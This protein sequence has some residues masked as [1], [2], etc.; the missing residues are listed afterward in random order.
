MTHKERIQRQLAGEPVDRIPMIGGWNMGVRNLAQI[1]G[2]SVE[3]YLADPV[4]GVLQANRRLRVDG[5]VPYIIPREVS[6]IRTGSLQEANFA[7]AEP[8]ALL[9][10]AEQIPATAEGVRAKHI[11]DITA[12]EDNYRQQFA[13]MQAALGDLELIPNFWG[14][15]A[16]FSLYFEYGYEAFLEA[17]ALY[18]E[19][20]ERI[21]WESGIVSRVHNEIIVKMMQEFDSVPVLLTGHDICNN[22]GPMCSPAMLHQCYWPHTKYALQP[23]VE[24]GIRLVHHCDGNVM[25]LVDDMIDSGFSGF[26]GF[27]YEC[28]VDPYEL[29]KHRGPHG[30]PII[31]MGGLSVTRTLPFGTVDDV[32]REVDYCLD[33]TDGGH[34]LFLFTSNVTGVEVPPENIETAYDYLYHYD[35]R[36]A[37]A[38]HSGYQRPPALDID[39]SRAVSA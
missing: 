30:E 24:A 25:P 38:R 6:D 27:Q 22:V 31:F 3:Q 10:R 32:K 11:T 7:A 17:T 29:R 23:F 37:P 19:A 1:G 5:V 9:E 36:T 2:I 33:F 21:W 20:V 15:P 28:T 4:A 14:A 35:P 34:G 26:Q 16:N 18:P 8:E 39:P 12:L 13:S